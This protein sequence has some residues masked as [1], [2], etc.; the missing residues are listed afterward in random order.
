[1]KRKQIFFTSDWHLGHNHVINFSKRPYAN[2]EEMTWSLVTNFN[3]LVPIDG[4]TYFLGDITFLG[5]EKSKEIITLLNGTK[6]L[7][8]GNHDKG[9]EASYNS[10]FD[11]VLHSAK[12]MVANEPVTMSHCPLP[13]L[14][15]EDT[16]KMHRQVEGELWHGESRYKEY[17]VPNEGQFHLHGHIHSPNSGQSEKILGRQYDVG[18]DANN[19]RPVHIGVIDSWISKTKFLE[20][21]NDLEKSK[22]L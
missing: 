11:M 18:V 19:Y 20:K 17:C 10:G 7:I 22:G 2:L 6:V 8:L 21:K 15:R 12:I 16:S 4:I 9:V 13:G 5:S 1:M 3:K 14:Y